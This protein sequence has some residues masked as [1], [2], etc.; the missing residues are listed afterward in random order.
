MILPSYREGLLKGHIEAAAYALPLVPADM[1]GWRDVVNHSVERPHVPRTNADVL[2][3]T[4]MRL[5]NDPAFGR[6]LCASAPQVESQTTASGPRFTTT[7][8]S[9]QL[10]QLT[11]KH[12]RELQGCFVPSAA[13]HAKRISG[14]S[15]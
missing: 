1:P 10:R 14:S 11:L 8:D 2:A 15:L 7:P 5:K 4:I 3:N 13:A 6:R 12:I 9:S